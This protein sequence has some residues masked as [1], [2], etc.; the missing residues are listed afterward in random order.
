MLNTMRVVCLTTF[1]L[2]FLL[3]VLFAQDKGLVVGTVINS[4]SGVWVAGMNVVL[5]I[6]GGPQ[7]QATTE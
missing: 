5:C 2:V 7:Y 1:G 3:H 4:T 6:P